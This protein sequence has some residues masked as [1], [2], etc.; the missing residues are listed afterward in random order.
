MVWALFLIFIRFKK[1]ILRSTWEYLRKRAKKGPRTKR[2][3]SSTQNWKLHRTVETDFFSKK[4]S[5][6][7]TFHSK[8]LIFNLSQKIVKSWMPLSGPKAISAR[9]SSSW[10][11]LTAK[12]LFQNL[13]ELGGVLILMF[14]QINDATFDFRS[15]FWSYLN[16]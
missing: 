12:I 14:D 7:V 2:H 15:S 8:I 13:D 9:N 1:S 5:L 4:I 6:K 16:E 3:Y 10:T 11:V